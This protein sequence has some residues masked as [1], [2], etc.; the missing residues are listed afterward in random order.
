MVGCRSLAACPNPQSAPVHA[1]DW[2]A[3]FLAL[4]QLGAGRQRLDKAFAVSGIVRKRLAA[5]TVLVADTIIDL[6]SLC[7]SMGHRFS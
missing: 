6:P 5:M 1:I 3:D 7:V 2:A 4:P